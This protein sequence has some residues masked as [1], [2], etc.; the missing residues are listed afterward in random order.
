[1]RLPVRQ[2]SLDKEERSAHIY[3]SNSGVILN[4]DTCGSACTEPSHDPMGNFI[5][6]ATRSAVGA[7]FSMS[8]LLSFGHVPAGEPATL[9][10][11]YYV[12]AS[13]APAPAGASATVTAIMRFCN[14]DPVCDDDE[15]EPLIP[16]GRSRESSLPVWAA[17]W[18][19][20]SG[21]LHG[22]KSVSNACLTYRVQN[23]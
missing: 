1:M 4:E 3:R 13:G 15:R 22:T 16:P 20:E 23:D 9:R 7:I 6:T 14:G 10:A 11:V 18:P 2:E 17:H 19:R 5:C 12:P 8:A 21:V